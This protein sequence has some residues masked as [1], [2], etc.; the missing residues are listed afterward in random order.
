MPFFSFS[1]KKR[2]KTALEIVLSRDN[3]CPN[4][5]PFLYTFYADIS[6]SIAFIR[7]RSLDFGSTMLKTNLHGNFHGTF[8]CIFSSH[9]IHVLCNFH[10]G[11][12]FTLS[13]V[14]ATSVPTYC[15]TMYPTNSKSLENYYFFFSK[16][17]YH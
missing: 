15:I 7:C 4:L 2:D 8:F 10:K 12:G 13:V 1:Q 14:L 17:Q 9:C 5:Q 6:P 3:I 11:F 16:Q